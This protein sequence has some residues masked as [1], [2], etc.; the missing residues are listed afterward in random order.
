MKLALVLG[1]VWLFA[2]TYAIMDPNGI[3]R[4]EEELLELRN[5]IGGSRGDGDEDVC[6]TAQLNFYWGLDM[7]DGVGEPRYAEIYFY[8]NNTFYDFTYYYSGDWL[9]FGENGDDIMVFD[10]PSAKYVS[11]SNTGEGS[12][13]SHGVCGS[14]NFN[15]WKWYC[16]NACL[17]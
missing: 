17:I 1:F 9:S 7:E 4:T 5:R 13:I 3:E 14:W 10:Y 8:Y 15:N 12:M 2:M 11:P 16:P 6:G